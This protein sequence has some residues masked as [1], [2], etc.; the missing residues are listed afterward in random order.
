MNN[1]IRVELLR[2]TSGERLLRLEHPP[3]GLCLEKR[4]N[5]AHPVVAQRDHWLRAFEALLE[6]EM[7]LT[8]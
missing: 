3:T 5:P 6:Q 2:L 7:V 8:P 4:L 1:S